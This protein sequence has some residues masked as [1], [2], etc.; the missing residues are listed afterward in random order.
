MAAYKPGMRESEFQLSD[1]GQF[2]DVLTVFIF[3]EPVNAMRTDTPFD[4]LESIEAFNASSIG[5]TRRRQAG[6]MQLNLVFD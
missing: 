1:H 3:W 4:S 5:I 2:L 6:R